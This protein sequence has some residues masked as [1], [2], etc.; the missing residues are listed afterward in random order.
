MRFHRPAWLSGSTINIWIFCGLIVGGY[1]IYEAKYGVFGRKKIDRWQEVKD[2]MENP[3][4]EE[5]EE[6]EEEEDY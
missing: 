1:S 4:I 6:E 3:Q 5:E 2:E